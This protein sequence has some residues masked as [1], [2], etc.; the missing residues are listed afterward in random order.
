VSHPKVILDSLGAAARKSLSQNFLVSPHW[1]E[2]L[3]QASLETPAEAL[4]EI[5]PGLGALTRG[6]LASAKVPVTVFEFDR[7]LSEH[8]RGTFPEIHLVEG[9]VLKQDLAS[10]QAGKKVSVL[11]NLPYHLS[12]AILFKLAELPVAPVSLVL[13]FQREFAA[14]VKASPRTPDY[15]ALSVL[16]QLQFDVESLGV[17]PPGAFYPAPDIDSEALR[18]LP[19]PTAVPPELRLLVKAAFEQ[20]RKQL[21][22]NLKKKFPGIQVAEILQKLGFSPLARAEELAPTDFV[23]LAQAMGLLIA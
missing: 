1:A 13:T 12:S 8:L 18:F 22:S 20:R 14:R 19:K 5:G 4:W 17:L 11:S 15:G 10:H 2:K 3:V 9:D 7:K 6:L 16:T 23:R 21:P